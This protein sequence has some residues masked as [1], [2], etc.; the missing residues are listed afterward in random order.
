VASDAERAWLDWLNYGA[1]YSLAYAAVSGP[2]RERGIARAQLTDNY[3][4]RTRVNPP[5]QKAPA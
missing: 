4:K 2:G 3:R 1:D 5:E